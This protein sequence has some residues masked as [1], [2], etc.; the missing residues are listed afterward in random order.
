M[1]RTRRA[2]MKTTGVVAGA[3]L[4]GKGLAGN[5]SAS[6]S[7]DRFIADVGETVTEADRDKVQE[8]DD[9]D[10]EIIHE[11][12]HIGYLVLRGDESNVEDVA[13]DFAPD[14]KYTIEPEST[15][16]NISDRDTFDPV[17]L[18]EIDLIS[19]DNVTSDDIESRFEEFNITVSAD[20]LSKRLDRTD[21]DL[22]ADQLESM[23]DEIESQH[24][25]IAVPG[26][27]DPESIVDSDDKVAETDRFDFPEE[28]EAPNFYQFQ[29]DKQHLG[30]EE[31]V[32]EGFELGEGARIGIVDSGI[33]TFQATLADLANTQK[34]LSQGFVSENNQEIPHVV[35]EDLPNFMLSV[36]REE[37]PSTFDDSEKVDEDDSPED[38]IAALELPPDTQEILTNRTTGSPIGFT[39]AEDG[40]EVAV[41]SAVYNGN[42]FYFGEP[43]DILN[44]DRRELG[45]IDA[46]GELE[47]RI[48]GELALR[49]FG[50]SRLPTT[51]E[52]AEDFPGVGRFEYR[53]DSDGLLLDSSFFSPRFGQFYGPLWSDPRFH[54]TLVAGTAA[55]GGI[56]VTGLAPEAEIVSL[57]TNNAAGSGLFGDIF[58][59]IEYGA[60]PEE[61]GGAGCDVINTSLGT[62]P[63]PNNRANRELIQGALQDVVDFVLANDAVHTTSA[64]NDATNMTE[65]NRL[66]APASA[67]GNIIVSATAPTGYDQ[68]VGNLD[69]VDLVDPVTEPTTYTDHGSEYVNVSAPGGDA[70]EPAGSSDDFIW[71]VLPREEFGG[72]LA[73]ITGTSFSAPQVAGLVA[74]VRSNNPDLSARQIINRIRNTADDVGLRTFHGDGYINPVAAIEGEDPEDSRQDRPGQDRERGNRGREGSTDDGDNGDD[75]DNG[76]DT[77]GRGDNGSSDRNGRGR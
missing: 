62:P 5:V 13:E 68:A 74:L 16:G 66:V 65:E 46:E 60:A 53:T 50:L 34:D 3:T 36:G 23:L 55:A 7:D 47:D 51:L 32:S 43:A 19:R 37:I 12:E 28:F 25:N 52:I 35:T 48:S 57:R 38:A 67:E 4:A 2:F 14:I 29:H 20:G 1:R 71:N 30:F 69:E 33:S 8:K 63:L 9:E 41:V 21:I 6:E 24:N 72:D 26:D 22:S 59:A 17:D 61:L 15:S 70:R 27:I 75:E 64:G 76:R 73:G 10:L 31:I 11:L 49:L 56:S 40:G 54:G 39:T 58:A 45:T 44:T 18:N 42:F 77:D